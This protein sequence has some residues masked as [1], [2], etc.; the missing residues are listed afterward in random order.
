MRSHRRKTRARYRL[1][2]NDGHTNA[3][4]TVYANDFLTLEQLLPLKRPD[5]TCLVVLDGGIRDFLLGR[6]A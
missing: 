5:S 6:L 2:V 1:M 3:A 4:T